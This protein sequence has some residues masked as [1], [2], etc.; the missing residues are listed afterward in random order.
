MAYMPRETSGTVIGNEPPFTGPVQST[1]DERPS[2]SF[3]LA[4]RDVP[5]LATTATAVAVDFS[6]PVGFSLPPAQARP[7]FVD[8]FSNDAHGGSSSPSFAKSTWDA[9]RSDEMAEIGLSTLSGDDAQIAIPRRRGWSRGVSNPPGTRRFSGPISLGQAL[10][11]VPRT[12]RLLR[13]L[14]PRRVGYRDSS[15]GHWAHVRRIGGIAFGRSASRTEHASAAP[16]IGQ[17]PCNSILPSRFQP[18]CISAASI[19]W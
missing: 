16:V 12:G 18:S 13:V 4:L 9:I 2:G 5:E 6:K 8:S 17:E 15:G 7:R 19:C 3:G 14:S 1:A 11:S 10:C